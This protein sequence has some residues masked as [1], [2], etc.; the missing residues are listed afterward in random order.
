MNLLRHKGKPH[1]R[2]AASTGSFRDDEHVGA[3]NNH[4]S[5]RPTTSKLIH[6]DEINAGEASG[7]AHLTKN[8]KKGGGGF[9]WKGASSRYPLVPDAITSAERAL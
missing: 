2:L 6:V 8:D 7:A 4:P 3:A 5:D 9:A 1:L